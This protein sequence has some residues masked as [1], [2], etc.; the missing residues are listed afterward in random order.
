MEPKGKEDK[1]EKDRV[2]MQLKKTQAYVSVWDLLM[3]SQKHC[4]ALLD[5][6]NGK[7]VLIETTS[8][9]VLS[10]MGVEGSLHPSL[11]FL[12]KFSLSKEL[13]ILD[14]C[15]SPLNAWVPRFRWYLLT[16]GPP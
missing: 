8:Q 13:L 16:M 7:E 2:L 15:K 10:L 4:K 3:A 5:A 12:M 6:L 1:E 14:L 9:E 11:P